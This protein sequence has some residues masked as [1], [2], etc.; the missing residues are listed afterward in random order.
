[1]KRNLV[2]LSLAAILAVTVS[3]AYAGAVTAMRV[4]VPFEFYLEDQLLPAGDYRF[5]MGSG[6]FPAAS[7]VTVRDIDG[8]GIR[9]V[10]TRSESGSGTDSSYL[11]FNQYGQRYFLSRVS[12]GDHKASVKMNTLE[13]ELRSQNQ[14]SGI[15][16]LVAQK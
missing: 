12:I 16:T 9:I 14:E 7:V 13:K 15:R 11:K 4:S 5:E 8:R 10:L 2:L 1:M 6:S 3:L